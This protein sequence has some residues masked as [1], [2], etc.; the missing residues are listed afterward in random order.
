MGLFMAKPVTEYPQIFNISRG[1]YVS[2]PKSFV[3][4]NGLHMHD[5]LHRTVEGN[6]II[7]E[8]VKHD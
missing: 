6:K 5:T 4:A 8:V 7:L 2:I 1:I 3:V